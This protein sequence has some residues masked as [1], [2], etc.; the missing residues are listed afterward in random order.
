MFNRKWFM[1]LFV[2]CSFA[3]FGAAYAG[4]GAAR[5]AG[6]TLIID[7]PINLDKAN[8]V[9]DVGQAVYAGHMPFV[10][11]DIQ[12][13]ASGTSDLNP[14]A[15]IFAVFHGEAAYLVLNDEAYNAN[16]HVTT[17]NPYATLIAGLKK[18][19]VLIELCGA[20][21][22]ANHWG[23]ANLLPGVRVN[24]S[25]MARVTQLQQLGYTLIYE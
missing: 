22:A 23:N 3:G 2:A 21:A 16:R 5:N 12:T 20:T 8:V 6:Q 14:P 18:Q 11:A 4:D 10:F 25:A 15:Q 1:V 17:G 24:T 13:L 19:G 9:F 7:I